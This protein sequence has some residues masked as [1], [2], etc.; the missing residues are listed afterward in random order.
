MSKTRKLTFISLLVAQAL[1][2]HVI[3]RAIPVPFITPGAK[4]GLANL[5]TVIALYTFGFKETFAI[6]VLR[7]IMA[8][9]LGGS[10]SSFLY[11]IAGGI[12]SFFVM[13]VVMQLGEENVSAIGVSV[14]GAVFHNIGQVLVASMIVQ[15]IRIVSYLPVLMVAGLGTGIFIGL[16]ARYLI[17]YVK[18]LIS[19]GIN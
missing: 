7:I 2:L 1:V 10:L 15:N 17:T 3:E 8:A 4:L 11:S 9:L 16:T 13:F 14:A 12:L 19:Y 6:V 18:K 5:V